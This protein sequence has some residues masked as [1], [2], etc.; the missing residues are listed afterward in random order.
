VIEGSAAILTDVREITPHSRE[1]GARGLM[2]AWGRHHGRCVACGGAGR[3]LRRDVGGEPIWV[4]RRCRARIEHGFR[5]P[6][7]VWRHRRA[8]WLRWALRHPCA[9]SLCYVSEGVAANAAAAL[10]WGGP[11]RFVP[12]RCESCDGWHIRRAA[13]PP[14]PGDAGTVGDPGAP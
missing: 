8:R 12:A 14:G 7:V 11:D 13:P 5:S 6:R 3:L 10:S 2:D 4:H 1:G 9:S